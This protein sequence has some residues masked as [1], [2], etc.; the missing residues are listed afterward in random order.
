MAVEGVE[1]ICNE[2]IEIV[3]IPEGR[4]GSCL[5]QA[6]ATQTHA[7]GAGGSHRADRIRATL[8]LPFNYLRNRKADTEIG[9]SVTSERGRGQ[10]LTHL[11]PRTR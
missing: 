6:Q 7:K 5:Q 1:R 3:R 11:R 2:G 4:L 9:P 10:G 8:G